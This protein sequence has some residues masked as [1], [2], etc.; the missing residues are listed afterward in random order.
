MSNAVDTLQIHWIM[1]SMCNETLDILVFFILILKNH[2]FSFFPLPR[3]LT[4]KSRI[5]AHP[6]SY[7]FSLFKNNN[8]NNKNPW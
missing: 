3:L 1:D 6:T 7:S 8:N 4:D 5:P 2:R